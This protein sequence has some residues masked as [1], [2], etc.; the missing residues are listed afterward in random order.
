MLVYALEWKREL[1]SQ[2]CPTACHQEF[3]LTAVP[4]VFTSV[5]SLA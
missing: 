1:T 5:G 2:V 4:S 3:Q